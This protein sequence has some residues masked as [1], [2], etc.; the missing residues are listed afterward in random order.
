V[1]WSTTQA[2][3][4]KESDRQMIAVYKFAPSDSQ[5]DQLAEFRRM[6]EEAWSGAEIYE[7]SADKTV[8]VTLVI[9]DSYELEPSS[10]TLMFGAAEHIAG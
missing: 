7:A 4:E 10:L 3:E 5:A 1:V 6:A 2:N 9:P 8:Y